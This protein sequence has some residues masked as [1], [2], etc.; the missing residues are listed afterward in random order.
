MKLRHLFFGLCSILLL[1]PGFMYAQVTTAALNGRVTDAG[2]EGLIAAT[3]V[4]VHTP[5][6]TRYGVTT[7]NDG[8]YTISNMRVGGPYTVEASYV[9]FKN[10]KV[11]IVSLNL[12]QKLSLDFSLKASNTLEEVLITANQDPI[13]NGERTGAATNISSDQL[14]NL[15][16]IARSAADFT[17]LNPMSA[18]GGSFAGRNDQFNNYSIDGTIFNNPFGLDAATP[19]GQTDAQPISLDAIEQINV[20]IAPY[21]VTQAGFTGASINAV[22]KSGTNEFHGTVFGFFR[23]KDMIGGKV[24]DVEVNRGD[25]KQLQTGFSLGGPIIKNKLFFFANLEIERRSDLGSYFLA[26]RGTDGANISRVLASDLELVSGLLESRY[27]YATGDYENYIHRTNNQKGILKLDWNISDKH[28]LTATYNFLDAF[29][30]KPAHPSAIGRRGPDFFTLQF[31]NSGY[32]INNKIQSGIIELKS[33]FSNTLSNKLQVGYTSFKDSRDPF[34]DPFPVLNIG[35]NGVRYIVAGHE[36][37]SIHNIL[38]QAV[39]QVNDNLNV[40]LGKHTLT[41]GASLEKFDFNNSFNLT[42]YGARVFFPDIDIAD[43]ESFI[44]SGGLDAEVEAAKETFAAN[45]ANDTWA[46]AET[47]LGQAALYI[48]D[49]FSPNSRLTITYGVRAD[50]PLYFDTAEKIQENIDRNCCYDPSIEYYDEDGNAVQFDHTVLPKQTPLISPRVGFNL[51][52]S[53][54]RSTQLRGGT[55]LFTGRFPFVWIGNQVA[56]PN[57]FFYCVTDPDFKFPQVWRS[58]LG[59]DKK[60]GDSW[61]ASLDIVYTKDVNA[62]IVRNYGLKLPTGQLEGPDNRN[63]YTAAD[64]ALAGGLPT[65]AYVFTNTN[66]GSSFNTSIQLERNFKNGFYAKIGYNFL[67]AKDAASIDAEISSDAYDRNPA[68]LVHTN[69]P[70]LAPSLYGNKHRVLGALSKKFTYGSMATTISLF[71]E[72]VAGGRYSYTYSGDINNDGSGLNDLLYVPT[73]AEIDQMAFSGDA[74]QQATQKADLKTFIAQDE[75]LSGL[76]GDYTEKYGALSPWFNHWDLRILQD[77]KFAD[78]HGIQLSIDVLNIGN[79]ISSKWGVRQYATYTGLAQPIGV[80][81]TDGVPTYSFA[82]QTSTFFNDFSLL[83]RWQLQ[84]G[85]RYAF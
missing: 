62:M 12:G 63:I 54:D 38:D 79:L 16:T 84:V 20:Q 10:E 77:L 85:L 81:V 55:G 74:G 75:Y 60:I 50:M 78:K 41:V 70:V 65:N 43:F 51:A 3:V 48:Q 13:L 2:G 39:F 14:R 57:S 66:L 28:K 27:G 35:K 76:R 53:D 23:N 6:G 33:L 61:V 58:N 37:F 80:S 36:P 40:Y 71:T 19:G 52:F 42:G 5:S 73:D 9:G 30:E 18:E 56:N 69:T 46:L 7:L 29:K 72:Y 4:A 49:E 22:T 34:S 44:N 83:S 21:D 68:N 82:G 1:S 8:R 67:D 45:N 25:L 26:N 32:R 15:P 64:R 31:A 59:F 47:N 17:R 24:A 11:E